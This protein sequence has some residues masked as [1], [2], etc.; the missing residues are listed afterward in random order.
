MSSTGGKLTLDKGDKVTCEITNDRDLGELKLVKKVT[1]DNGDKAPADWDLS[2]AAAAPLN[3]Y[4]FTVAGDADTFKTV[5]SNTEYTLSESGPGNCTASTWTCKN[6]LGDPVSVTDGKVKVGKSAKVTCEITNDRNTAELKLV[7]KVTGDND[8]KGPNDWTLS[9]DATAPLNDKN[10]SNL[11]GQ[12]T[13]KSV[14]SAIDYTLSESGPGDYTASTWV[15]KTDTDVTLPVTDGKVT[16]GKDSKVTCEITN[17]RN[18]AELKLVKKVTGDNDAKG[19]NDW[20]LSADATAPLN[21]KNFSN[22]GGQGTFKTIYSGVMYT[23]SES[24][25]GDYTAS[26]WVCKDEQGAIV[27]SPGGQIGLGKY[28][29]VTCEITND[30]DTAELKLVKK[31][32]G[33]D[34]AADAWTLSAAAT[35][36]LND[37]NF[38][39]L[40]GQGTFKS[41]YTAIE[42]TLGETGPGDYSP[43]DWVCTDEQGAP[44]SSTGGKLTLDKGDKVTCEITNDRDLGELKLVK[45]VTGDNGDKAPADWD[46]RRCRGRAAERVQLHRRR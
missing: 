43:S 46:L 11:G 12:G 32:T 25:P 27:P 29:K 39:N 36:P 28:G 6:G 3:G 4:N 40:G 45:K 35:A 38:S 23:L 37:K 44:V 9:A 1:G 17:D 5:F 14:Y 26:T 18:T 31:V 42:Y 33:G 22:L 2:A 8:A 16:L 21:D 24:G 10:F 15:C 7:K 34:Q 19:P 13:F 30:R 20:T 41:V